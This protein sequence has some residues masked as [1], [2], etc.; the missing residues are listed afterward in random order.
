MV[1]EAKS[2]SPVVE[3]GIDFE[4][5]PGVSSAVAVPAY[6][7]IPLTHRE[8]SSNVVFLT[9]TEHPEKPQTMIPWESIAQIGTV[10]VM[11]GLKVM[12]NV[13]RRLIDVGKDPKTPVTTIQWGSWAHHAF[14]S[15]Y[16]RY[17][18]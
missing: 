18:Y 13:T 5:V 8:H 15:R 7:G 11:M 9:G 1:E 16:S 12:E 4:V 14:S 3:A 10:V 6:A 2:Y 17:D